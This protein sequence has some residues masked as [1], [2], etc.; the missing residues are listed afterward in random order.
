MKLEIKTKCNWHEDLVVTEYT[1]RLYEFSSSD[2]HKF[3][4]D[5]RL[6]GCSFFVE[7][8]DG[9]MINDRITLSGNLENSGYNKETVELYEYVKTNLL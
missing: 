6:F 7:L 4:Y 3:Q 1:N 8:K 5:N 2:S 9:K